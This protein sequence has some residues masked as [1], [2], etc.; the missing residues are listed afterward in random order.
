MGMAQG[1]GKGV[2]KGVPTGVPKGVGKKG[3]KGVTKGWAPLR[4]WAPPI[5]T[6]VISIINKDNGNGQA[7]AQDENG[8]NGGLEFGAESFHELGM[9]V[10]ND[11]GKGSGKGKGKSS[12]GHML[13]R[14]RI[15]AE[16]FSGKVQAWK[17]KY[18]WI[19]PLEEIQ[20]EKASLH[21]GNIFVNICDIIGSSEL[22]PGTL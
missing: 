5:A 12:K 18:G 11:Y 17:G 19:T 16:K 7:D 9:D 20:H 21:N 13:P 6:G 8:I 2:P 3:A 15:T 22:W 1:M 4:G 14:V 10:G